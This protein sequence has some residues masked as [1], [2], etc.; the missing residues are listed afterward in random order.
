MSTCSDPPQCI[1]LEEMSTSHQSQLQGLKQ[2]H[3]AEA[4]ANKA[5][6]EQA[7]TELTKAQSD[8]QKSQ[9]QL[10]ASQESGK[11]L[12]SALAEVKSSQQLD[13][14]KIEGLTKELEVSQEVVKRLTE[15]V[16]AS[17][18]RCNGLEAKV[19]E[20]GHDAD[21]KEKLWSE[22]EEASKAQVASLR[23]DLATF[24]GKNHDFD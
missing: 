20:M 18:E 9:S 22:K 10:S 19:E 7:Q 2:S 14:G 6:L 12:Q 13:Q 11:Q 8:L 17:S 15:Q 16:A 3:S 24:N 1:Q 21:A 23:D 4:A 5:K